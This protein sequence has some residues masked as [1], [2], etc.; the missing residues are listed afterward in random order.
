MIIFTI[1]S[2]MILRYIEIDEEQKKMQDALKKDYP[3]FLNNISQDIIEKEIGYYVRKKELIQEDIIMLWKLLWIK[4]EFYKTR[5]LNEQD[6]KISG[7][8]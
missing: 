8:A 3:Y 5:Y 6:R 4:K 7:D 1:T 2:S